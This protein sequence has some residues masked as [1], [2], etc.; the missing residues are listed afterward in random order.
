MNPLYVF[1]RFLV[2]SPVAVGT[3]GPLVA[4]LAMLAVKGGPAHRWWDKIFFWS[5]FWIFAST[6]GLMFFRFNCFLIIIAILSF[7]S[8]LTGYR[9]LYLECQQHGNAAI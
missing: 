9:V 7:Y 4:P 2:L 8:A 3:P 1:D 5:M 6:L